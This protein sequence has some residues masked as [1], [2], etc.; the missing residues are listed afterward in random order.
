M[1]MTKALIYL[2]FTLLLSAGLSATGTYASDDAAKTGEHTPVGELYLSSE[3]AMADLK[4]GLDTARAS[5]KLA[6]VV[7]G[8]NWCHDSRALAARLFEDPLSTIINTNFEVIFIDVGYLEKGKDVITSLGIPVYYATPTVLIIDPVTGL[9]VNA[10]N[11]NLW[12]DAA[13]ISMEQSVDYFTQ[14]AEADRSTLKSDQAPDV[15]LQNLL[16]DIDAFEQIQ[17]AR[18]YEA[19]AVLTPML[20]AYKEG[21]KKAFSETTWNE[22]RNYRYKVSEDVVVLRAEART[23]NA[24]GET[25]IELTYPEYPAFSW[26][27]P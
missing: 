22:V 12:G 5:D 13:S 3:D 2:S 18:L 24:S 15:N 6:L 16:T 14:F 20:R 21:D 19:Y 27:S 8:A 4:T 7:M 10:Q 25:D 9:V 23:R 17:A 1:N 26:D 11:R